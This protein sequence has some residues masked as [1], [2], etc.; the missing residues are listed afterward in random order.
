MQWYWPAGRRQKQDC[1][2]SFHAPPAPPNIHYALLREASV[3]W[4]PTALPVVLASSVVT[5]VIQ[6][7]RVVS[8]MTMASPWVRCAMCGFPDTGCG[9][10][11]I[12]VMAPVTFSALSEMRSKTKN[13]RK[14]HFCGKSHRRQFSCWV[15]PS[16]QQWKD[17]MLTMK[18]F[19]AANLVLLKQTK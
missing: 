8:Q 16:C 5:I 14:C 6:R 18:S 3:V 15:Q 4:N 11:Q 2:L 10:L 1:F 12:A 17:C 9:Y 7:C 19:S 13:E